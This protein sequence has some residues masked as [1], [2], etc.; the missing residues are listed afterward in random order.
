MTRATPSSA[1]GWLGIVHRV[2]REVQRTRK[3]NEYAE[4]KD[5]ARISC[6][7]KREWVGWGGSEVAAP[8]VPWYRTKHCHAAVAP[9]V[10]SQ[11]TNTQKVTP[12]TRHSH[13]AHVTVF[14]VCVGTD[15]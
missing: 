6:H 3:K 13:L 5:A 2:R 11:H 14:T 4:K 1:G 10:Y 12:S 15:F 9:L 8:I 7:E